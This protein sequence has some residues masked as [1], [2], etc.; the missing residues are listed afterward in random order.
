MAGIVQQ[1]AAPM[2]MREVQKTFEGDAV[3]EVFGGM[4][5]EAEID[6][7]FLEHIED[8]PPAPDQLAKTLVDQTR[9]CRRVGVDVWPEQRA[10]EGDMPVEIEPARRRSCEGELACGPCLPRRGIL[11]C[12]LR[13]EMGEGAIIGRMHGHQLALPL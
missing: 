1:V 11:A 2:V 5:L 7:G 9:R 4:Q 12:L 13:T 8:R 10:A 3:V 6:A